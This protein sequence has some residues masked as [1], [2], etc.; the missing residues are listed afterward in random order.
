MV[1]GNIIF[2]TEHIGNARDGLIKPMVVINQLH[3]RRLSNIQGNLKILLIFPRAKIAHPVFPLG[4]GYL[5]SSLRENP[6]ITCEILD[7]NLPGQTLESRLRDFKPDIVG[8]SATKPI[9]REAI[10]LAHQI[11]AKLPDIVLVAGGPEP[12]VFPKNFLDHFHFVVLKEGEHTFIKLIN[13]LRQASGWEKI[14]GIAFNTTNGEKIITPP[15]A[16]IENLDSL[17]FP[18]RRTL[19][20]YGKK[21]TLFTM[22]GCP[23]DCIFCFKD[24]FGRQIR[25]HS[26]DKV[27]EEMAYI[28][29]T[30]GITAFHF[31]DET[32]TANKKRVKELCCKIRD[33]LKV[34]FECNTRANLVSADLLCLMKKAGCVKIHIGVESG[35]NEVLKSLNKQSTIE[36]SISATKLAHTAG[37]QVRWFLIIGVPGQDMKS[38]KKT[39]EALREG[40]PDVVDVNTFIPL[41]GSRAFLEAEKLGITFLGD[42]NSLKFYELAYYLEYGDDIP[43]PII[44]TRE[45]KADQIKAAISLVRREATN[46]G[47]QLT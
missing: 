14:N 26:V 22:R 38:I 39:I 47:I 33:K 46:L 16:L 8:I 34:T 17:P 23:F 18:D 27:I 21:A 37:I 43:D 12:T 3:L 44:E 31:H 20:H 28:V 35:D 29:T 13:T 10:S 30:Y 2:Q 41:K 5:S 9:A 36:E 6:G 11:Q 7:L 4:L 25:T 45:M 19:S 1:V 42:P 24:M 40:K 15:A 32:F